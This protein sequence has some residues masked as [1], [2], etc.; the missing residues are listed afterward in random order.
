MRS[1]EVPVRSL[2]EASIGAPPP[3]FHVEARFWDWRWQSSGA[4]ASREQS[5]LSSPARGAGEDEGERRLR[6]RGDNEKTHA[7][8]DDL[9][10]AT[11]ALI[12][13]SDKSGIVAFAR[14][15]AGHGIELISTGGTHKRRGG[16]HRS[17]EA[18]S[19]P[20][21]DGCDSIIT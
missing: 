7:M 20:D 9:R 14:A 17:D 4:N 19:F 21:R 11:R 10:R 13:V 2:D 12:S 5:R 15:L 1:S 6:C 18:L 8:T 16:R 3:F